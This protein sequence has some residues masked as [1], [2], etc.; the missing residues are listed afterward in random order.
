[1]NG[2]KEYT[3]LPNQI[4]T[5]Y[6]SIKSLSVLNVL[7]PQSRL[8]WHELSLA[9]FLQE[10]KEPWSRL[11]LKLRI[12]SKVRWLT[13]HFSTSSFSFTIFHFPFPATALSDPLSRNR[14]NYVEAFCNQVESVQISF[15]RLEKLFVIYIWRDNCF[16]L[17]CCRLVPYTDFWDAVMITRIPSRRLVTVIF[18]STAQSCVAKS[19]VAN[20]CSNTSCLYVNSWNML[21]RALFWLVL[22][23]RPKIFGLLIYTILRIVW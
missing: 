11:L 9:N 21:F 5:H 22:C 10:T 4:S 13:H 16:L 2:M 20:S 14:S 7:N 17:P 23:R 12:K 3:A 1:M 19:E 18:V 15:W 8:V 6:P